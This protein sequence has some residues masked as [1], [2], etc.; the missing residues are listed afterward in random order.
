MAG[1]VPLPESKFR[2]FSQNDMCG[3]SPAVEL[4][5]PLRIIFPEAESRRDDLPA[6]KHQ[7]IENRK[8]LGL[9]HCDN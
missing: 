5:D 7:L 6:L 8:V 2:L 1:R 3:R 9:R 4:S